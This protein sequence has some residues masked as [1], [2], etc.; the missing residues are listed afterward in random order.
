MGAYGLYEIEVTNDG[1]SDAQNVAASDVLPNT[2]IFGGGSP[3]CTVSGQNPDGT[4]GT[5]TCAIDT[6]EAGESHSFLVGVKVDEDVAGGTWITNTASAASSTLDPNAAN[7]TSPEA[8]FTA[9]DC[10]IPGTDLSITKSAEP[11]I[12]EA[13]GVITYQL[14]ITN[15]GPQAA[16]NVEVLELLPDGTSVLSIAANNPDFAS[17]FCTQS[18]ICYLGTVGAGTTALITVVLQV[19]ADLP[20][21]PLTNM[22]AVTADQPDEAPENNL[23]NATVTVRERM[24]VYLPL[25][26]R[27][28]TGLPPDLVGKIYLTPDKNDWSSGEAVLISVVVTNTGSEPAGPFWVD[29][30]INPDTVPTAANLLWNETCT[31]SPCY[32]IAWQQTRVLDPGESVTLTST[33]SSYDV[34]ESAWSGSFAAGTTDLYLWVDSWDP[35]DSNGAVLERNELN[36]GDARHGLIVVGGAAQPAALPAPVFPPRPPIGTPVSR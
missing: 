1:P 11:A 19:D 22:A 32:G 3:A 23:A 10:S 15:A 16:T 14:T 18:G 17:E 5:V 13:G 34:A 7:N 29:L 30:Y 31:L 21:G 9:V 20:G 4:G 36:N 26:M 28:R 6:L 2:L 8:G 24:L 33:P 27:A 35:V 25:I 12:V